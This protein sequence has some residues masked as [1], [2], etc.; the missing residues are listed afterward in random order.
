MIENF[1]NKNI[2]LIICGSISAYKSLYL[3][4]LLIKKGANVTCV[5]TNGAKQFISPL[6]FASLSSN[7]V[8]SELFDLKDETEMGH[9]KLSRDNDLILV[10]PASANFIAKVANGLANDLATSL[11]LAS[12]KPIVLAPSMN[13]MM[14]NNPAT[15]RNI[16][17]LKKDNFYI[18]DPSE[19]NLAC[20]EEGQGRMEEPEGI[21]SFIEKKLLY[22]PL[23]NI[24]V[25][26]TAGPTQELIDPVRYISNKSSG[27]QG[28]TLAGCLANLGAKV[29]LVS[30]PTYL[31]KP[32]GIYKFIKVVTA[33]EMINACESQLPTSI[34]IGCAAVTDW[35]VKN[36]SSKKI[37]KHSNKNSPKIELK[38]NPDILFSI[39]SHKKRPSLVIGFSAETENV[40]K[41]SK[42]KLRNKMC[43]MIIANDVS[44]KN[45]VFGGEMNKVYIINKD[46]ETEAW[47]RMKKKKVSEK[48]AVKIS[49][50]MSKI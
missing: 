24:K 2:L 13:V 4:R 26:I 30:G 46:G 43:D 32:A 28:Y 20:G 34:F 41:N 12:N 42:D 31:D 37:K 33:I 36:F 48:I 6:S 14:W 45:K 47:P 17:F 25:L 19:G 21:V 1:K 27:I 7:K 15:K 38:K 16:S 9:I 10:V 44:T 29:I 39:S 23:N 35:S 3:L 18:I 50:L 11:L 40:I 49:T 22:K 8:Y 5:M